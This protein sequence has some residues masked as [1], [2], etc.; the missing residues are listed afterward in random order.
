MSSIFQFISLLTGIKLN[1][2]E[3]LPDQ[4]VFLKERARF[5]LLILIN[6]NSTER[7][8]TVYYASMKSSQKKFCICSQFFFQN[9]VHCYEYKC[10]NAVCSGEFF[11]PSKSPDI[12]FRFPENVY[13]SPFY[14]FYYFGLL[15]FA[16]LNSE[17]SPYHWKRII[18]RTMTFVFLSGKPYYIRYPLHIFS[19]TY[20]L[21][22]KIP[23]YWSCLKHFKLLFQ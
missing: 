14:R 17:I 6:D 13:Y 7:S 2:V 19:F 8:L 9:Y 20:K 5:Y 21:S 3:D 15:P 1:L 18:K 22:F 4:F 23:Q 10:S 12:F 16:E 11:L